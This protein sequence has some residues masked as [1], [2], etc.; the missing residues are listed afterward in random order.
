MKV[1]DLVRLSAYGL[2][3]QYNRW[4][5]FETYNAKK[6]YLVG[7]VVKANMNYSF[8]Y[9]VQWSG[10]DT[11]SVHPHQGSHSR[12]ELKYAGR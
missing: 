6:E 12:L 1:G 9:K 11:R 3:R 10:I 8:P 7:V 4:L 5:I 2:S